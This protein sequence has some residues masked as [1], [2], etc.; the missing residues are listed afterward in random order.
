MF[1]DLQKGR[2]IRHLGRKLRCEG[3]SENQSLDTTPGVVLSV[4][5]LYHRYHGIH[6]YAMKYIVLVK[7]GVKHDVHYLVQI[8]WTTKRIYTFRG[9]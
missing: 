1:C 2:Q 4:K 7:F 3:I 8:L 9:P 5:N 6:Q